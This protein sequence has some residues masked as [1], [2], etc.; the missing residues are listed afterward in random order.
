MVVL[1]PVWTMEP[2][3][4]EGWYWHWN[5]CLDCAPFPLSI[6]YSGFDQKC[7]VTMGNAGISQPVN[8]DEYGGWWLKIEEPA[9]PRELWDGRPD[10]SD[11]E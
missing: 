5:G 2:P 8:C 9:I 3:V 6:L 10:A 11:C 7:F 4:E 1:M